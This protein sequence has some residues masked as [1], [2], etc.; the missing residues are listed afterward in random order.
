VVA[1]TLSPSRAKAGH[2]YVWMA[3]VCALIAFTAFAGTYWLQVPAGTFVGQPILHL[4]AILFSA[5]PLFFLFQTWQAANGRLAQH[6]AWGLAGV[7]LATAMVLVGLA[8]AVNSVTVSRSTETAGVLAFMIVPV[9]AIAV[10]GVLVAAAIANINRP[11]WHKRLMLVATISILQAAVARYVFLA[12][13][14]GGP[15]KRPGLGPPQHVEITVPA[16][17]AIDMLI[18]AAIVYDWRTRGRPH[19]A[20]LVAGGLVLAVQLLRVPLSST[21]AWLDTAAALA[22]FG[23]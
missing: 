1:A 10:F 18:V 12:R 15:G 23:R 21:P 6:R 8:V 13:T 9:S 4:H 3:G 5:W 22:S 7:S 17:L 14:G 20:Y 2:F 19:P 11:E 16:G